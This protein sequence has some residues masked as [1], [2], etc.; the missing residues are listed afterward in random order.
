MKIF[1]VGTPGSG[2][3][4]VAKAICQTAGYQYIDAS[5]W[6]KATFRDKLEE[7]HI[8]QYQDEYHHYLS[9]RIKLNPYLNIDNILDTIQSLPKSDH[10]VMDGI[11]SPKDF[12]HLFNV[13]E[14]VI[15][16][17][18]RTDNPEEF[19]DSESIAVSVIRDYC[20]WMS[21]AGLLEKRRWIEYNFKIPGEESEFV[22]QLG[23]KNNVFL[24][25]SITKVISHLKD[26]LYNFGNEI[27]D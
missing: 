17:L 25:K 19:K 7:E 20:Y 15:V 18:N 10:I 16:F 23:S 8:Q 26:V 27:S 2:R 12:V 24:A 6:L 9:N 4:T 3:T 11:F 13:N 14:D 1:V 22:K 21:S 5:S